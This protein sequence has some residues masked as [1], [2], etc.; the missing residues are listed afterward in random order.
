MS[1]YTDY[2]EQIE[3]RKARGC[4]PSPS[5]TLSLSRL[6]AQIDDAGHEHREGSLAFF[7]R[8]RCRA[9]RVLRV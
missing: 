7:I 4:T 3:T 9:P 5:K 2:L 1:L 8:T 6:I